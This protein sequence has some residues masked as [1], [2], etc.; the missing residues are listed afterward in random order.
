MGFSP[1]GMFV[2]KTGSPHRRVKYVTTIITKLLLAQ[3]RQNRVEVVHSGVLDN[4]A[5][6][7]LLVLD[8]DLQAEAALEPI[9]R[10]VHVRVLRR[11]R[12]GDLRLG[13]R[14]GVDEALDVRLG[15]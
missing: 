6:S 2:S 12:G 4:H 3:R 14:L 13:L 9:L 11:R 7:A 5:A 10:L 1:W 15:L 8:M